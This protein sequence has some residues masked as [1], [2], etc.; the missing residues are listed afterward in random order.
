MVGDNSRGASRSWTRGWRSSILKSPTRRKWPRK[1]CESASALRSSRS[2]SHPPL[3]SPL[4]AARSPTPPG[5]VSLATYHRHQ[6][7]QSCVVPVLDTP[8]P[9]RNALSSLCSMFLYVPYGDFFPVPTIRGLVSTILKTLK[10]CSAA[11]LPL[12]ASARTCDAG[13]ERAGC[14]EVRTR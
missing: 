7:T 6:D 5:N 10:T 13:A 1:I 11:A 8:P 3:P 2:L 12:G 4:P 14:C 9:T